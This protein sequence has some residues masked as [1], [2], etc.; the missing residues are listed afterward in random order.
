MMEA[1][2]IMI[3]W[4]ENNNKLL[5]CLAHKVEDD[6]KWTYVWNSSDDRVNP[7]FEAIHGS[8]KLIRLLGK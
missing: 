1:I 3:Y 5:G 4:I 2:G 6:H 7:V 8:S